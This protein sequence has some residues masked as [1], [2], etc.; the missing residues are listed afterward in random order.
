MRDLLLGHVVLQPRLVLPEA[1]TDAS[2]SRSRTSRTETLSHSLHDVSEEGEAEE[3]VGHVPRVK[4]EPPVGA[5]LLGGC[6]GDLTV[7]HHL[8]AAVHLTDNAHRLRGIGFLHHLE[9]QNAC[10]EAA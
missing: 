9:N 6:Q 3:V 5:A 1:Y 10:E 4:H 7:L 8:I 2:Q